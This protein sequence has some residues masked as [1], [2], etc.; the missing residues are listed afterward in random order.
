MNLKPLKPLR[1]SLNGWSL[2]EKA[3][4]YKHFKSQEES[5]KSVGCDSF[6]YER[7]KANKKGFLKDNPFWIEFAPHTP[8][9][10]KIFFQ[11]AAFKASV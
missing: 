7:L 10:V 6:L 9:S 4:T 3:L 11:P 1:Y 5:E 2:S 8:W